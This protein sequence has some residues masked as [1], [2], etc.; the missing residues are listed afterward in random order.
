MTAAYDNLIIQEMFIKPPKYDKQLV[1]CRADT[2]MANVP[3]A[4]WATIYKNTIISKIF[5]FIL[6]FRWYGFL[7]E[8]KNAHVIFV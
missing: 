6:N 4:Y 8:V 3:V 1:T 5:V 7:F 2:P